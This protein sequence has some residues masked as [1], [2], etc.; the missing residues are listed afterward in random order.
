MEVEALRQGSSFCFK[1][2]LFGF[3][4]DL[5]IYFIGRVTDI[6]RPTKREIFHPLV[7]FPN[8][9]NGEA[10]VTRSQEPSTSSGSPMLVAGVQALRPST[11]AFP[12]ALATSWVGNGAAGFQTSAH[13]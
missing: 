10:E 6:E 9:C 4:K 8:A 11:V 2:Y 3:F 12:G 5:F 7:H 13:M 1:V